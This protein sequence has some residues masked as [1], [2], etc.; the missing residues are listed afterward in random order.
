MY[1]CAINIT[2]MYHFEVPKLVVLIENVVICKEFYLQKTDYQ[3]VE[4]NIIYSDNIKRSLKHGMLGKVFD[5]K[6]NVTD[7]CLSCNDNFIPDS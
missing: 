3:Y 6:F 5:N 1:W 2:K 4:G 7:I